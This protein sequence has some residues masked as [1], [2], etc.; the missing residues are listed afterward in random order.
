ME[1]LSRRA[2][3]AEEIGLVK[4]KDG[5]QIRDQWR[6]R[7]VKATFVRN[8]IKLG[9]EKELAAKLAALLIHDAVRVQKKERM[10]SLRGR[11]ALVVGGSGK[12]GAWACR[13]LSC[14][15]AHVLVWDPRGTLEGYESVKSVAKA[16]HDAD[17]VL[18][19]SPLGVAGKELR[20]VLKSSPRGLVFDLCSIKHHMT[21]EIMKAARRGVKITSVHPMFGPSAASPRGRN[22]VVCRCGC[23][24]ADRAVA[25]L[26][27]SSGA[28][29][30]RIQLDRHDEL[31]TYV[32]GLPHLCVLMF[33]E[34][35]LKSEVL[36]DDL[37][38]VQG[39]SFDRLARSAVELSNESR[40]V[41][42][43]IQ[44]LNPGTK[45]MIAGLEKGLA[46]LKAAALAEDP[47]AFRIIMDRCEEHLKVS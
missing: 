19:A 30:A 18:I 5:L 25:N 16:A 10:R 23:P 35:L 3:V 6:E 12:M 31:M 47:R 17:L 1:L 37:R 24:E 14:R 8:A 26:F 11:T 13:F 33:A 46:E 40:R 27:I 39:P 28:K 32:L 41:Y 29:V 34:T 22:V 2:E 7:E 43:D 42:H 9:V 4:A 45:R 21:R 44:S 20:A 36:I 15:G 38:Q